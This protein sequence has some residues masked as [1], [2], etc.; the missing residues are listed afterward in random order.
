MK[1]IIDGDI[2]LHRYSAKGVDDFHQRTLNINWLLD[3]ILEKTQCDSYVFV[4][5]SRENFRKDIN[6]EY[7]ANRKKVDKKET[8]PFFDE[9]QD[10]CMEYLK[11]FIQ[12]PL[13]ADDVLGI[14]AT[15]QPDKVVI[16]SIDKDLNT[17]PGWHYNW[18]KEDN[19]VYLVTEQEADNEF[20]I[21][22][23]AGDRT[24]NY[25]GIKGI[26][27][28]KAEKLLDKHG[29]T[30]EG[31]VKSYEEHDCSYE[32]C[33]LNARMARILRKEDWDKENKKVRLW[34]ENTT[35]STV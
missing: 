5:S 19:T 18:G 24:D 21:Q 1:A 33:L 20:Y 6:P 11:P 14:Y 8:F 29:W 32:D 23:L 35:S 16:C 10:W 9:I 17:V 12:E 25:F 4:L 31:V 3:K 2:F 22:C 28:K 7:K 26:G 13:E 34:Q 15:A 30:W 27:P